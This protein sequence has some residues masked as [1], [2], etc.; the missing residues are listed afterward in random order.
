MCR[1]NDEFAKSKESYISQIESAKN[2]IDNFLKAMQKLQKGALNKNDSNM[3]ALRKDFDIRK[4]QLIAMSENLNQIEGSMSAEHTPTTQKESPNIPFKSLTFKRASLGK[5]MIE[6]ES[7]SLDEQGNKDD[8]F[9]QL[10][11]KLQEEQ[12]NFQNKIKLVKEEFNKEKKIEMS[13]QAEATKQ[14]KEETDKNKAEI[15]K[16]KQAQLKLMTEKVQLNALIEALKKE[17]QLKNKDVLK[18]KHQS[19]LHEKNEICLKKS[20]KDLDN[21]LK[22]K[23][24]Q[25]LELKSKNVLEIK[26]K[27]SE[28]LLLLQENVISDYMKIDTT[29]GYQ[30]ESIDGLRLLLGQKTE[31][32]KI[33]LQEAKNE[34]NEKNLK[35]AELEQKFD[36]ENSKGKLE[37]LK[38]AINKLENEIKIKKIDNEGKASIIKKLTEKQKM[39][40]QNF[41]SQIA[42]KDTTIK[43]LEKDIQQLS[44]DN[45]KREVDCKNNMKNLLTPICEKMAYLFTEQ[46]RIIQEKYLM[47]CPR[48]ENL[49]D[50]AK[51]LKQQNDLTLSGIKQDCKNRIEEHTKRIRQTI[52]ITSLNQIYAKSHSLLITLKDKMIDSFKKQECA[53]REKCAGIGPRLKKLENDLKYLKKQNNSK[54]S[55]TLKACDKKIQETTKRLQQEFK[56]KTEGKV[57]QISVKAKSLLILLKD[58]MTKTF[59]EQEFL[60]REKYLKFSP[61][62][63]NIINEIKYLK[64][65][66]DKKISIIKI[67]SQEKIKDNANK[68]Y[69]KKKKG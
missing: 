37:E 35:I 9:Y 3:N 42:L 26:E 44:N 34:I 4:S 10:K 6:M 62:M 28:N 51:I 14:F 29:I 13:K 53:F 65:E 25:I 45:R 12:H 27:I 40:S 11:K 56:E 64:E 67:Y 33:E 46:E 50:K 61:R 22:A 59:K 43:S 30:A 36:N 7:K 48:L 1:L 5:Q 66:N 49:I 60:I 21:S 38:E 58:K 15:E 57:N 69:F 20:I 54:M 24:A 41:N 63:E 18:Y 32:I 8:E 16:L 68:D 55:S 19:D 52:K 31:Q 17:T 39:M 23:N 2:C 47:L